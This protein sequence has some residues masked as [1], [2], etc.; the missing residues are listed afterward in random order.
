MSVPRSVTVPAVGS[1]TTAFG[2]DGGEELSAPTGAA[3]RDGGGGKAVGKLRAFEPRWGVGL[4]LC[5]I[6]V[7]GGGTPSPRAAD[8]ALPPST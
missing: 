7:L 8:A 2:V 3:L 1:A 4:A 6:S 5:R